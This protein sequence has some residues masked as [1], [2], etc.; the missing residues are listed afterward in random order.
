MPFKASDTT[1]EE[2]EAAERAWIEQMSQGFEE[3]LQHERRSQLRPHLAL[4]KLRKSLRNDKEKRMSQ[5][6]MADA[7]GVSLR[8]YQNYEHGDRTI[9]SDVLVKIKAHF[10]VPTEALLTDLIIDSDIEK[11][12]QLVDDV[13]DLIHTLL[14]K[15]EALRPHD[16]RQIIKDAIGQRDQDRVL[17]QDPNAGFDFGEIQQN[18]RRSIPYYQE[19]WGDNDNCCE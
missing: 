16:L 14:V 17:S 13:F 12:D 10:E 3:H 18:I 8:A 5:T 11:M 15:Y 9:P 1:K 2:E 19:L 6:N 4:K 7:L